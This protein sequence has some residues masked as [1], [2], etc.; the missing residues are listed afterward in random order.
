MLC[1]SVDMFNAF[2][3]FPQPF[4]WSAGHLVPLTGKF[5]VFDAF[6]LILTFSGSSVGIYVFSVMPS[7]SMHLFNI[8]VGFP[9]IPGVCVV[10]FMCVPMLGA[11]I[12]PF[13][14]ST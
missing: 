5:G 13:D 1:M 3:W 10:V 12:C 9:M 7:L 4:V 11:S 8:S 14:M 2:M 6:Q